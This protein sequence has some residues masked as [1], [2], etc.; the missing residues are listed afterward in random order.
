MSQTNTHPSVSQSG[1]YA[2]SITYADRFFLE[3]VRQMNFRRALTQPFH[4]D[5]RPVMGDEGQTQSSNTWPFILVTDLSKSKGDQVTIDKL[6]RK[7][8]TP[9]KGDVLVTDA[10]QPMDWQRDAVKIGLYNMPPINAGGLMSE[11]RSAHNQETAQQIVAAS[12]MSDLEDNQATMAIAGGRGYDTSSGWQ[13]PVE[14]DPSLPGLLDNPTLPPTLNRYYVC[15]ATNT[16]GNSGVVSF[17]NINSSN[18]ISLQWFDYLSTALQNSYYPLKGV[19]MSD[20][21]LGYTIG[22]GQTPV[23]IVGT[24]LEQYNTLKTQ[25][26]GTGDWNEF[27]QY[28]AIRESFMK[29]PLFN[30]Q[31]VGRWRN[32][33]FF[34]YGRPVTYPVG[35]TT[36]MYTDNTAT[37]TGTATAAVRIQRGFVLG[38]E[39]AAIAFGSAPIRTSGKVRKT[40]GDT[41]MQRMPY[42]WHT[43]VKEG[44]ILFCYAKMM[45]GIK[46][47][48][49]PYLVNGVQVPYDAGVAVFDSFQAPNTDFSPV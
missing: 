29:H 28:T 48:R 36:M 26:I 19:K 40:G 25:A 42:A 12:Y 33:I 46:K 44:S 13:F 49:F 23:Y 27:V 10:A 34:V 20:D 18:V 31:Q 21:K 32:C 3:N 9:I 43:E 2:A 6:G 17:G 45:M 35:S 24:T 5:M 15:N 39:A 7:T 4:Q 8:G 38:A 14:N 11:Q 47:I 1:N 30:D 22:Q 37:T 16:S 41:T